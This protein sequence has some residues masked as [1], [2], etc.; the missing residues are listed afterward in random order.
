MALVLYSVVFCSDMD[1]VQYGILTFMTLV[2]CGILPLYS[3]M[4]TFHYE[5]FIFQ[6]FMIGNVWSAMA[7]AKSVTNVRLA[8]TGSVRSA[9]SRSESVPCADSACWKSHSGGI[10]DW[11]GLL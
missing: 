3:Q 10:E 6:C 5:H 4:L 8:T 1:V 7:K 2:H 9:G 11:K